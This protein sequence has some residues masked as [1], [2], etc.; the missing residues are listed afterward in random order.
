MN[1]TLNEPCI[2]SV[3]KLQSLRANFFTQSSQNALNPFS[4]E[5]LSLKSDSLLQ[6]GEQ[7]NFTHSLHINEHHY[8]NESSFTQSSD[9]K[10]PIT[11][12]EKRLRVIEQSLNAQS[13]IYDLA[14]NE[15]I[16]LNFSSSL[17]ENK[18]SLR[19]FII[20]GMEQ[21]L[22]NESL[23]ENNF[24]SNDNAIKKENAK[25]LKESV[26]SL[27]NTEQINKGNESFNPLTQNTSNALE[28]LSSPSSLG[29][30][31]SYSNTLTLLPIT[32]GYTPS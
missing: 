26:T 23:L 17:K 4:L 2:S 1:N 21:E 15:S 16:T 19:D 24:N 9:L 14:L 18:E 25:H 5:S 6:E 8:S 28:S 30:S 11:L 31:H 22:I 7:N 20:I 27:M 29:K 12:K 32:F 3:S 10:T 13:N